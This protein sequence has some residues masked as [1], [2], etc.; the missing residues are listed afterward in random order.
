MLRT[1]FLTVLFAL[2]AIL[3][4]PVGNVT[5]ATPEIDDHTL[6]LCCG[7]WRGRC[8]N[9]CNGVWRRPYYNYGYYYYPYTHY[10]SFYC[11]SCWWY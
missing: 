9:K 4:L 11:D 7:G 6:A 2:C 1:F 10:G 5:A 8:G 3:S